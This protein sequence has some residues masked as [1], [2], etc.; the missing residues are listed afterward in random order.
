LDKFIKIRKL[1]Y[2]NTLEADSDAV[3]IHRVKDGLDLATHDLDLAADDL[4]VL[5]ALLDSVG[6]TT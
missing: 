1:L 5:G 6:E 3:S 4:D 2:I